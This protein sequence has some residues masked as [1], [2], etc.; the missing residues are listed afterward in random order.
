MEERVDED[1]SFHIEK[2]ML[3]YLWMEVGSSE[4]KTRD[5]HI[6]MNRDIVG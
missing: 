4:E 1:L 5:D 3:H 2:N 6:V